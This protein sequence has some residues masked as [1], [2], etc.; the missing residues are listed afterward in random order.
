M[1]LISRHMRFCPG[2]NL[3]VKCHVY[4]MKSLSGRK[5]P[6]HPP[7]EKCQTCVNFTGLGRNAHYQVRTCLDCG[8]PEPVYKNDP[9]T[10]KH[11]STDRRGSSK[12]TARFFCKL[13]GTHV[14]EM[15]H[16][17]AR[18]RQQLSCDI[19]TLPSAAVDT[20]ARVIQSEKD[21]VCLTIEGTVQMMH[22]FQQDVE[23]ELLFEILGNCIE[24]VREAAPQQCLMAVTELT[25]LD[26]VVT[27]P[28]LRVIDIW[29]DSDVW[30]VLDEGCNAK[31]CGSE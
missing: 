26:D 4:A 29:T 14:D 21:D 18:R 15:P 22:M 16:E 1:K 28:A 27:G 10:C 12:F 20:A 3:L 31:A 11:E 9:A 24:E 17:E 25:P 13:C 23:T 6:P 5:K 8:Q 2:W 30:G 19:S 7:L